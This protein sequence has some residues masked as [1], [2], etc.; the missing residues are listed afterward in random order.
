MI[1]QNRNG[2]QSNLLSQT[3]VLPKNLEGNENLSSMEELKS[4]PNTAFD[5]V[6][7]LKRKNEFNKPNH[8]KKTD[9]NLLNAK[10]LDN[11]VRKWNMQW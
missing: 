6:R 11:L 10:L 9:N 4:F 5:Y 2:N 1:F 7:Q 3:E 8:Q